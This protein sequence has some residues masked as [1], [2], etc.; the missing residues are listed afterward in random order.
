MTLTPSGLDMASRANGKSSSLLASVTGGLS[1]WHGYDRLDTER[2]VLTSVFEWTNAD[3]ARGN[4]R[5]FL[6]N[7]TNGLRN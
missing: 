7:T 2:N 5:S 3:S 6:L 1:G 4:L